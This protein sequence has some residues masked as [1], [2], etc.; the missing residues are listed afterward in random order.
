MSYWLTTATNSAEPIHELYTAA[1]GLYLTWLSIRLGILIGTW[2]PRSNKV[3]WKTIRRW[4]ITAS[5]NN[6]A[7]TQVAKI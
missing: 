6:K 2:L 7:I 1:T 3:I 4:S 5:S